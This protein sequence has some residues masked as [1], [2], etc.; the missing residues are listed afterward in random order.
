MLKT[1]HINS[2]SPIGIFDIGSNSVRFV[3]YAPPFHKQ[4]DLF[5]EKVQ[6]SL[7][8]DLTSTG[9]LYP[10]GKQRALKA[11]QGFKVIA[12]AMDVSQ[13]YAV[14]T[15]ALRDAEDGDD[16]VNDVQQQTG[17]KI[18][19]IS[20]EEEAMLSAKSVLSDFPEADGII[21]DLGGGSLE[22]ACIK[23][24]SIISPVSYPLGVLRIMAQEN[25]QSY[26]EQQI[27]DLPDD[28]KNQR[29]F[30]MV[31]GT[32]RALAHLHMQDTQQHNQNLAGY[33]VAQEDMRYFAKRISLM[34]PED[35]LEKYV[36]SPKRATMLPSASNLMV[37]LAKN[38]N[39][40]NI[41]V[42]TTGLRNGL[43]RDVLD[44]QLSG[45]AA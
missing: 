43:L 1:M 22:L 37:Q 30:Y 40:D 33:T 35:I 14:G 13:F 3:V 26:I 4:R 19:I 38:L 36:V 27:S 6:C 34:P 11:L 20:G 8:K 15:A 25:Q 28:L 31:G 12:E 42:S 44:K 5:N 41:V 24:Q 21:G 10:A 16:F 2:A 32:W 9:R 7:G 45:E 18:H 23:R 29:S 17:F 39:F